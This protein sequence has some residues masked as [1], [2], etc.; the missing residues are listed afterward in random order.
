MSQ[1]VGKGKAAKI[2]SKPRNEEEEETTR[3]QTGTKKCGCPF[4]INVKKNVDSL[5]YITLLY[6][7][8]TITSPQKLG[9]P[10]ICGRLDKGSEEVVVQMTK[11]M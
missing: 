9:L 5:W 2:A 6:V 1:R 10:F 7:G 3:T 4:L 11:G 8:G